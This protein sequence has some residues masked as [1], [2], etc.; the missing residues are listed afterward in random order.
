LKKG[1]TLALF[2][3]KNTISSRRVHEGSIINLRIDQLRLEDGNTTTREVVEHTG[4]VVIICQPKT[5]LVVLIKQYRYSLDRELI[6]LPAG[7][8]ERGEN[9]LTTA[10][11]ELIEETG[12]KANKWQDKGTLATAPGFCDE[13]L[14]LFHASDVTVVDRQLDHDEEIE[15]ITLP[16]KE[17][18]KLATSG[19]IVDSKTIAALA[20]IVPKEN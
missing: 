13:L 20:L 6:E 4:G 1:I 14:Y 17:A 11:R 2:T 5:D 18:W 12:Y 16:I 7:R 3:K 9:P 10:K 8:I 19:N 15:V